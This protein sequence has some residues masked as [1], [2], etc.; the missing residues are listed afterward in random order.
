MFF[1]NLVFSE[2]E[3]ESG[4]AHHHR[5]R[6][7]F[8]AARVAPEKLIRIGLPRCLPFADDTLRKGQAMPPQE[9]PP[10]AGS[11]EP[12]KTFLD[13]L[14]QILLEPYGGENPAL[15]DRQRLVDILALNSE[16]L[17]RS[18]ADANNA[19][20]DKL[21]LISLALWDLDDGVTHPMF[22]AKKV[23]HGAPDRSD[24]WRSRT[25]LAI[26]FDYLMAAG[27]PSRVASKKIS[28][29]P[30]IEKLLSKGAKAETS[31]KNWRVR[32]RDG[33][34]PNELAREHWD[35]F[36][37]LFDELTGSPSEK[38]KFLKA[39]AERLIAVAVEDISE[40]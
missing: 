9:T 4:A 36:R 13:H 37:K 31:L 22:K 40:I 32:L 33:L 23:E 5:I 27:V 11:T 20:R 19:A 18:G 12:E 14:L 10:E 29:I 24:I 35:Q 26:A 16:Y 8:D 6:S 15:D 38:R 2:S 34:F 21:A 3:R 30:G 25:T 1:L 17:Q 39:E 7:P 28:K